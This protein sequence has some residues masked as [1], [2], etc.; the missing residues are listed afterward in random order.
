MLLTMLKLLLNLFFPKLCVGCKNVLVHQEHII[1]VTCLHDLPLTNLHHNDSKVI[2]NI[3][4]GTVMLEHATALFYFPKKGI[5]RQLIH[6]L[7]Y[8]NQEEISSYIGKWLSAELNES[9]YYNDVDV[10][11]PVPLHKSRMKIR[12]YNQV[13]GFGKELALNL[14]AE[15]NDTTLLRIKNTSTQ[16]VKNRLTRW[17]NVETIFEVSEL[18][19]LKG[20][21]ILLVDDVIT[22]G[23]TIKACV[24]ELNKIP[25]VKLSLAVMAYTDQ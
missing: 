17:K 10:V 15:Y 12:G 3:F 8:K 1:C 11:V 5:V 4:Y 22:T 18:K 23:A 20:K 14:N 16:T 7:K 13:E 25:D 9:G 6:Q 19:S 21:R 24:A 2:S